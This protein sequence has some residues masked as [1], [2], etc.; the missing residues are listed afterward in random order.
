[1]KQFILFVSALLWL[2]TSTAAQQY[3]VELQ[4]MS[5]VEGQL[6]DAGSWRSQSISF[7]TI[8]SGAFYWTDGGE[9]GS[10]GAIIS[11]STLP[12]AGTECCF[13]LLLGGSASQLRLTGTMLNLRISNQDSI[14]TGRRLILDRPIVLNE[15]IDLDLGRIRDGREIVLRTTI[16]DTRPVRESACEPQQMKLTSVSYHNGKVLGTHGAGRE[17]AG[18]RKPIS[19]SFSI[20]VDDAASQAVEYTADIRFSDGIADI[21]KPTTSTLT[22]VRTYAIDTLHYG[23]TPANPQVRYESTYTRTIDVIPGRILKIVIPPD[24]P[25]V[26]GFAIEDTLVIN[27][28][29]QTN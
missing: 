5:K 26:R 15:P 21:N 23:Y 25:S 10:T 14:E 29:G 2:S 19:T 11:T 8:A 6:V 16:R 24:T 1:M 12:R 9:H 28:G 20:P 18:I 3:Y 22:F 27:P 7:S 4:A 17:L 13:H